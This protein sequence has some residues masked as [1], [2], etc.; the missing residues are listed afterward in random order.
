VL[1]AEGQI[2]LRAQLDGQT[3]RAEGHEHLS[4]HALMRTLEGWFGNT[5]NA[6]FAVAIRTP[7]GPWCRMT[8]RR[9]R[10][11]LYFLLSQYERAFVRAVPEQAPLSMT[12]VV[13]Q[14]SVQFPSSG[15]K[16]ED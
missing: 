16:G 8:T 7:D 3:V 10:F 11:G 14:V 12:A 9:W 4:I 5:P 2:E 1:I 13:P 15:R 6:D